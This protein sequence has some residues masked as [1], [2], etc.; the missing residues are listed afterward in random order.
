MSIVEKP[1]FKQ[2]LLVSTVIWLVLG[3]GIWAYVDHLPKDLPGRLVS[4]AKVIEGDRSLSWSRAGFRHRDLQNRVASEAD[5]VEAFLKTLRAPVQTIE[6]SFH[7]NDPKA[8]LVTA[9]KITLGSAY[10]EST[11]QVRHA[12]YKAWLQQQTAFRSP[13]S[14]LRLN[15]I[16]DVLIA[17]DRNGLELQNPI[18]KHYLKFESIR[19]TLFLESVQSLSQNCLS[20]WRPPEIETI[21]AKA[22]ADR[23]D[24]LGQP[25]PYG[26]R[27]F[28]GLL[29]WSRFSQS[30]GF[31]RLEALRQ[32]IRYLSQSSENSDRAEEETSVATEFTKLP[33][34]GW[35]S[36]VLEEARALM[37]PL[38]DTNSLSQVSNQFGLNF[39]DGISVDLMIKME[40]AT[41]T[42][43]AATDLFFVHQLARNPSVRTLVA[44]I[45]DDFVL[46]P[47][48]VTLQPEDVLQIK[49]KSLVW[50]SCSWPKFSE[51]LSSTLQIERFFVVK[52]C[53]SDSKSTAAPQRSP[54]YRGYAVYGAEG[55]AVDQ[56]ST[57][58]VQVHR[59]SFE[60]AFKLGLIN[61][62]D[63][64]DL[65][66]D[67]SRRQQANS[68][69]GL[70]EASL[71]TQI[72]AYRVR[73]AVQAFEWFR[74]EVT[75]NKP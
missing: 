51:L 42:A 10:I 52:S 17:A 43:E 39:D 67:S 59:A 64:F 5:R 13:Q 14:L 50:E 70:A 11:G 31:E 69:L 48:Q 23:P 26:F 40:N 44:K 74:P 25:V 71:I 38:S 57:A 9:D 73:A 21:C 2:V 65:V 62:K 34:V 27:H 24:D 63:G 22:L 19:R 8:F 72:S 18:S 15:V 16:A 32:W 68:R 75:S 41:R 46:L 49:S 29:I 53:H 37:G 33:L 3:A 60:S 30:G 28:L 45:D 61:D 55:F 56:P 54:Q 58:F 36:W 1:W 6:F 20:D 66:F 35:R 12:F 7:V 4:S 47:G